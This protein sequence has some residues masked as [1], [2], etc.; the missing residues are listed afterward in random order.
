[1]NRRTPPERGFNFDYVMW[2]FTRL[3]ALG[4]YLLAIIGLVGALLMGAR[5]QVNLADLLR[6]SFMP[7]SNHVLLNTGNNILQPDAW[8][9]GF[10][11]VMGCAILLLAGAHGFHGLL[12][13][14][15]D[16]LSSARVRI[17][18]RIVVMLIWVAASGIGIY[19]ILT[20]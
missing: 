8:M 6:W 3:S 9:A 17:V 5:N 11:R 7:N 13:V 2:L 10:W 16:Y 4:M 18:L 14:I 12:N 15:E 1:M 20:S 19:V